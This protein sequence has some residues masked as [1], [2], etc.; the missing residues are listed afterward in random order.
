M[1]AM[2]QAAPHPQNTPALPPQWGTEPPY[3][4]PALHVG[5]CLFKGLGPSPFEVSRKT[6][7]DCSG[8]WIGPLRQTPLGAVLCTL[9]P[10]A[11]AAKPVPTQPG[12]HGLGLS[13]PSRFGLVDAARR[14][15]LYP[16]P[17]L[18]AKAI[19]SPGQVLPTG[20]SQG[21]GRAPGLA[22]AGGTS[23]TRL[24]RSAVPAKRGQWLSSAC[25]RP[26]PVWH[27]AG[28][29]CLFYRSRIKV[30]GAK[31]L[32]RSPHGPILSTGTAPC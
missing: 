7:M 18:E 23:E 13:F 31:I 11:A 4:T 24:S 22:G 9:I 2:G 26:L 29:D 20:L 15:E 19:L 27:K 14:G 3:K 6:P 10:L 28:A 21:A 17:R 12:T 1:S 32:N 5:G 25:Q 8:L 16:Y 30:G